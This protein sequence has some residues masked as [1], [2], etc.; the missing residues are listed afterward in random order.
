MLFL[1]LAVVIGWSGGGPSENTLD[2][3]AESLSGSLILNVAPWA[4]VDS[5]IRVDSVQAISIDQDLRT[6]CVV[7][8]PPGRYRVRVS[9][10]H[11]KGPLEFE[12]SIVAGESSVVHTKLPD[13][14]LEE[15]FS[16]VVEM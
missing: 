15:T 2:P 3:S 9:N 7:Q 10:P 6:P 4:N 5:I 11:F 1:V 16:A 14:D 13:F 12:V 8:M